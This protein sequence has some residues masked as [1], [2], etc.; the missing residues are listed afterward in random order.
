MPPELAI[1]HDPDPSIPAESWQ[2]P[3]EVTGELKKQP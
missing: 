2:L 1:R 3:A